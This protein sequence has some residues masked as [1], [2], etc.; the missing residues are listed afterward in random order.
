MWIKDVDKHFEK[1]VNNSLNSLQSFLCF[2]T[3]EPEA[4]IEDCP[5]E[6]FVAEFKSKSCFTGKLKRCNGKLFKL[7]SGKCV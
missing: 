5:D 4:Y 6:N 1:F 7:I 2:C 3:T